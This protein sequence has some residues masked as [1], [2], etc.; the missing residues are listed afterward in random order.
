[1]DSEVNFIENNPK[2]KENVSSP[3]HPFKSEAYVQESVD[4]LYQKNAHLLNRLSQT[5]KENTLLY[6]KLSSLNKEKSQLGDKNLLLNNKFSSLKK[7]ISIFAKQHRQ[8]NLQS[9]KLK[10]DLE[11]A[12]KLEE[13]KKDSYEKLQKD[14]N[15]LQKEVLKQRKTPIYLLQ[16]KELVYTN[17]IQNLQTTL[18]QIQQKLQQKTIDSEIIRAK[19]NSQRE[20]EILDLKDKIKSLSQNISFY[21]NLESTKSK[22]EWKKENKSLKK[23][24]SQLQSKHD[25][26]RDR[27]L[28]WKTETQKV[29]DKLALLETNSKEIQKKLQLNKSQLKN[30]KKQKTQLEKDFKTSQKDHE[31]ALQEVEKQKLFFIQQEEEKGKIEAYYQKEQKRNNSLEKEKTQIENK[32]LQAEQNCKKLEEQAL[33]LKKENKSLDKEKT[34][35]LLLKQN[36]INTLEKEIKKLNL[37]NKEQDQLKQKLLTVEQKIKELNKSLDEK[38]LALK[39]KDSHYH[40]LAKEKEKIFQA[41]KK[42]LENNIQ[43]QLNSL[44]KENTELKKSLEK[45]L[46]KQTLEQNKQTKLLIQEKNSLENTIQQ[47]KASQS[48]QETLHKNEKIRLKNQLKKEWEAKTNQKLSD[49]EN[50]LHSLRTE[51]NGLRKNQELLK[52][53]LAKAEEETLYYK[54]KTEALLERKEQI[55]KDRKQE[56]E[57]NSQKQSF[58]SSQVESLQTALTALQLGFEQQFLSFR[59][60]QNQLYQT[61]KELIAKQESKIQSLQKSLEET[62]IKNTKNLRSLTAELNTLKNQELYLKQQNQKIQEQLIVARR[63]KHSDEKLKQIQWQAEQKFLKEQEQSKE[64]RENLNLTFETQ[65]K[66]LELQFE[67]Q[68]KRIQIE[69]E[70]DLCEE[71]N[72]FEVFKELREQELEDIQ[73]NHNL[74]QKENQ[75][76]QRQSFIIEKTL[77]ENKTNLESKMKELLSER[78]QKERLDHLWKN[79]QS[80]LEAKDQQL[81]SLQKL[82]RSLSLSLTEKTFAE[83][84]EEKQKDTP[85]KKESISQL[86]K[87]IHF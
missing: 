56:I 34:E 20:K 38:N 49:T 86:L 13:N 50:L 15:E 28:F 74:L 22:S 14:F 59:S 46:Q 54:K 31:L 24:L 51:K 30:W 10:E 60:K 39:N 52:T 29:S 78:K 61:K 8:F 37:K 57:I 64:E 3:S 79:L 85:N 32:L 81:K 68:K 69:L 23:N 42:E 82:N 41:K 16:K 84:P 6:L 33:S 65:I 76:L 9:K 63:N 45:E 47:L 7:Q 4:F 21:Q 80:R 1:M 67:K 55:E 72:R 17:Q 58:L 36:H 83:K 77:A 27:A 62:Q 87:E 53:D 40:Q 26:L 25:Y 73:K 12:S 18:K 2:Q 35:T 43:T 66:K 48:E 70:N 44:K 71:K 11:K 5:G 75:K 19:E